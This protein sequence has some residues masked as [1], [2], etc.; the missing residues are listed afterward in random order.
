[1]IEIS[2]GLNESKVKDVKE[3]VASKEMWDRMML[4][5]GGDLN[6]LRS[7]PKI[8]R[9]NYDDIRIKEGEKNCSIH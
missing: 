6:I 7:K 8:I 9:L 2:F 3:F 1:M 5:H 4:V